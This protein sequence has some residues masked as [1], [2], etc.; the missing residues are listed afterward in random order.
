MH[1]PLSA[2][3][4]GGNISQVMNAPAMWSDWN[5]QS[6]AN[7]LV[8]EAFEEAIHHVQTVGLSFGGDCQFE[9]GAGFQYSSPP[10]PYEVFSSNFTESG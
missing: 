4:G 6:A 5:G 8:T 10:P 1:V 2:S 7:P 9:T 3:S